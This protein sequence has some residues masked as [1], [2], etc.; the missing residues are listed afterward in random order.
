[1]NKIIAAYTILLFLSFGCNSQNERITIHKKDNGDSIKLFGQVKS[2]ETTSFKAVDILG[3]ITKGEKTSD[4][5]GA[6][7]L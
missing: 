7:I 3:N 2:I 6:G 5:I 4:G 1:M